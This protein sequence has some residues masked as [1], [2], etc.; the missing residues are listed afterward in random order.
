MPLPPEYLM[1]LLFGKTNPRK[2]RREVKLRLRRLREKVKLEN[3]EI[4]QR[5]PDAAL[6]PIV[7]G[8]RVVLRRQVRAPVNLFS[9]LHRLYKNDSRRATK[10]LSIVAGKVLTSK[11]DVYTRCAI[12][13]SWDE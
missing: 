12:Q 8:R 1:N 5:L 6:E 10:L 11:Y 13:N 7:L 4:K 9:A 3:I 2:F